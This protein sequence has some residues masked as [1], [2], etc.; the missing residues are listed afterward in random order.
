MKRLSNFTSNTFTMNKRLTSFLFLILTGLTIQ[1]QTRK[2][3][4]EFLAIGVGA[5][6]L[7]MSGATVATVNDVTSGYWNPAGLTGLKSNFQIALMHSEYFAGIAKYDYGAIA[8]QID[9]KSALG[10]SFI[11]FGVDDIPNTTELIDANGQIDYDRIT[12]FSAADYAFILSYAKK[13]KLEGLT[14]G[15]NAKV[16]RR[17]VGDFAGAWGFGLDA[18]AQYQTEKW[19]LGLMAR[20]ITSTFNSWSF[21]LDDETKYVFE[22]TGNE[23]PQNGLE[24]TLPKLILGAGRM[25]SYKKFTGLAELNLDVTFD[26]KRNVLL[27][28]NPVSVD[29][30][31]GIEIGYDNLIFLRGG[32]GNIQQVQ[33]LNGLSSY[34]TQ[35]NIG[36][37]VKLKGVYI[38]YALANVGQ[39][40]GLVSHVF[41]LKIDLNPKKAA[42]ETPA[43]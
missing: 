36:V 43:N 19:K 20:D 13:L 40:F 35:P 12:T 18:G 8:K 15:A 7:G 30:H 3:S 9:E 32:I 17:K 24:I 29:P 21:N 31:L 4:N 14:F 37:G 34:V 41:S 38:D 27:R 33:D 2:Y 42:V 39:T 26:G 16:I 25:L 10:I 28:G 23:L 1:A 5:R 11:R 6:S 22:Q